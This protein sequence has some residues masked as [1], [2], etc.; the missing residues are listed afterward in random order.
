[1]VANI[2]FGLQTSASAGWAKT[3][4][5]WRRAWAAV[6]QAGLAESG[7]WPLG[8]HLR[9]DSSRRTRA[10][11]CAADAADFDALNF[12]G[13]VVVHDDLTLHCAVRGGDVDILEHKVQFGFKWPEDWEAEYPVR[14]CC[15]IPPH[16]S[17]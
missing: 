5:L 9:L 17:T 16:K 7:V 8:Y 10:T 11:C 15:E 6:R 3:P 12:A 14:G 2:C 1:M 4:P 13:K